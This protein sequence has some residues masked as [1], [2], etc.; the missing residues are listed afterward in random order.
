MNICIPIE[1]DK[2]LSSEICLHF[3]SAPKYMIVDTR[4]LTYRVVSNGEGDCSAEQL[5]GD[6]IHSV[7]V[8]GIGLRSLSEFREAGISVVST[9][10]DQVREIVASFNAGEVNPVDLQHTCRFQSAGRGFRGSGGCGQGH[11]G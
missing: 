11:C 3:G 4:T 5:A 1:E 7:V 2:G 6:D 9:R 10:E 8:G